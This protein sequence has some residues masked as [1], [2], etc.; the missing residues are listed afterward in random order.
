MQKESRRWAH[1]INSYSYALSL[2]RQLRSTTYTVLKLWMP[3]K[4]Q[5]CAGEQ[6]PP[7]SW[8]CGVTST[9]CG[10]WNLEPRPTFRCCF[11]RLGLKNEG[12]QHS[13]VHSNSVMSVCSEQTSYRKQANVIIVWAPNICE[14][15]RFGFQPWTR[16]ESVWFSICSEC[17]TRKTLGSLQFPATS[18][19]TKCSP[20]STFWLTLSEFLSIRW[21]PFWRLC[22]W[23]MFSFCHSIQRRE[24][25]K[26]TT[27]K[28]C[29]HVYVRFAFS[30]WFFSAHNWHPW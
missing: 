29:T 11:I 22:K 24:D 1:V 3:M 13:K 18:Q 20:S 15:W 2:Q 21:D 28:L 7:A 23:N 14:S 12:K 10:E 8:T 26:E 27:S 4:A 19:V 25:R 16:S 9:A 17:C 30:R 5:L 6:V